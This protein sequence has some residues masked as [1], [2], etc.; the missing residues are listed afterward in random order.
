MGRASTRTEGRECDGNETSG[1]RR[2]TNLKGEYC[3]MNCKYCNAENN[4]DATFCKVCGRLLAG[5]VV[6][7]V[8]G[9]PSPSGRFCNYCGSPLVQ[10]KKCTKCGTI[11]DGD[12]C[13][14]CYGEQNDPEP[15]ASVSLGSQT[16]RKKRCTKCGTI[17]EGERCPVCYPAQS[18]VADA[19]ATVR[20]KR[21]T[22]CGT[23]FEGERCP[24]C[25]PA[26]SSVVGAPATARKKRC[27]K[28]GTIFEGE[29]CP[30]CYGDRES[31]APAR[32]V[33][34]PPAQSRSTAAAKSTTESY[35]Q[36]G[37]FATDAQKTSESKEAVESVYRGK[38]NAYIGF[39]VLGLAGVLAAIVFTFLLG[40]KTT[41]KYDGETYSSETYRLYYFFHDAY[42]GA[43]GR[44][45]QTYAATGSVV[46]AAMMLTM[47]VMF[48]VC[49]VRFVASLRTDN[50]RSFVRCAL[51]TYLLYA[52]FVMMFRGLAPSVYEDIVVTVDGETTK[53]LTST[54]FNWETFVGLI[55]GGA[56][57]AAS[58]IG[59]TVLAYT[60]KPRFS[61]T[62]RYVLP[63]MT[64]A[65]M[66]ASVVLLSGI[67]VKFREAY[68]FGDTS[69]S[70][71]IGEGYMQYAMEADDRT[72]FTYGFM[73]EVAACLYALLAMLVVAKLMMHVYNPKEKNGIVF[74]YILYVIVA[75]IAVIFAFVLSKYLYANDILGL[76]SLAKR[77]LTGLYVGL[78]FAAV[79]VVLCLVHILTKPMAE[80]APKNKIN[81]VNTRSY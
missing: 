23:I 11:F 60:K 13:P 47:T 81:F 14:V 69:Y 35:L 67:V 31:A 55:A 50:Q 36:S 3:F 76:G 61:L 40:W 12:L 77:H 19:P 57:A 4:D 42:E 22:K 28:C 8:C 46:T 15:D 54:A 52:A 63:F 68:D 62:K 9:K 73:A 43:E 33:V 72:L 29:R 18:P 1:L 79:S 16:V 80:S 74:E 7:P 56:L 17:F 21:C 45:A 10:R 34:Y 51:L 20:K 44:R 24:V 27:T 41:V 66:V 59:N 70:V 65:L 25:Y 2:G 32:S 38:R 75:V 6:C 58:Y 53:M 48:V 64:V 78:S 30:V 49:I 26:Q 39:A 5:N 71:T 37:G